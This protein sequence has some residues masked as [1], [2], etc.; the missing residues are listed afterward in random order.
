MT[1]NYLKPETQ[2]DEVKVDF[3]VSFADGSN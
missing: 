2:L 3:Q 1:L